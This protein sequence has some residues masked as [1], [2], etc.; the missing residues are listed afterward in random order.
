MKIESGFS[1]T[2][3]YSDGTN[4]GYSITQTTN[5]QFG[6]TNRLNN[7]FSGNTTEQPSCTTGGCTNP[8]QQVQS[9]AMKMVESLV[10]MFAK[11]FGMDAQKLM[12]SL[13]FNPQQQQQPNAPQFKT[14]AGAIN[15]IGGKSANK[16]NDPKLQEAISQMQ[17]E[18]AANPGKTIKKT[19]KGSDGKKYKVSLD[20]NGQLDIK[21]K[22][23]G[24]FSKLGKALGGIVKTGLSLMSQFGSFIPGWGT[25]ASMGSSLLLNVMNKK[26]S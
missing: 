10:G 25:L 22:S 26:G 19:I 21:K 12:Q 2:T 4:L 13:G 8:N 6:D 20:E 5:L 15:N 14:G 16:A 7:L 9:A 23:G 17:A 24:F 1:A 11:M 18:Q 3:Q